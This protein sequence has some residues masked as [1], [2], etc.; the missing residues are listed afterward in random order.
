MEFRTGKVVDGRIVLEDDEALEEG[1][2]VH[3]VVGDPDEVVTVTDD[4]LELIRHGQ[5]AAARGD[6]LDA[7]EFL[8][9]L[10]AQG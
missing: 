7:R 3:V 2:P 9:A 10:R 4:E 6:L 5:A 1:A 8:A